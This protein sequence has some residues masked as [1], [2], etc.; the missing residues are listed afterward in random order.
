VEPFQNVRTHILT[1]NFCLHSSFGGLL[2][3]CDARLANLEATKTEDGCLEFV[4][5]GNIMFWCE[6]LY[7]RN[8]LSF[9]SK[10]LSLCNENQ[11]NLLTGVKF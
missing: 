6:Y 8:V 3:A 7:C 2:E 11:D 1:L 4:V 10:G 5:L 9:G